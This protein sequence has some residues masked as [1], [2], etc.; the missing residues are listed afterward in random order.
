MKYYYEK[1]VQMYHEEHNFDI[2]HESGTE[3]FLPRLYLLYNYFNGDE[4][5]IDAIESLILRNEYFEGYVASEYD[6]DTFEF[7]KTININGS[8]DNET[9]SLLNES[10]DRIK[11]I[12]N[13]FNIS[14]DFVSRM[15]E[16]KFKDDSNIK[17]IYLTDSDLNSE[18]TAKLKDLVTNFKSDVS[19]VSFNIY[20]KEDITELID[21]VEN[22]KLTVERSVIKLMD[23][24]QYLYHGA[25]KSL[26]VSISAKSLKEIYLKYA[27]KGLFSSN[28]RYYV[29]SARIDKDIKYSIEKE[30]DSFWYFNN[31]IIITA[32]NYK[33]DNDQLT[34]HD[35][36]IVNGGQTTNLIGNSSIS[37]DFS[38][39][40]KVIIPRTTD[41]ETNE[42]FL[43]KV[44]E[45]S[46]TQKPIRARDL[47]ANRP[48]QRKF[49][50]QYKKIDVFLHVKRGEKI[51][52]TVYKERWQNAA[53][54]EVGQMIF[55]FVYQ[56][57]GA[58]K[59]SKSAMLMNKDFYKLIYEGNYSDNLLLSFQHFKVAFN[60]W[61]AAE[62]KS[63]LDQNKIAIASN[64]IFMFYGIAG[65]LAK[66]YI[67]SDARDYFFSLPTFADY[68]TKLE[69]SRW[70]MLNDVAYTDVF[71]DPTLFSSTVNAYKFFDFIYDNFVK[72]AYI[73]FKSDYHNFGPGHF[74]KSD[75]HYTK[76]VIRQILLI[77]KSKF[78][79]DEFENF[80]ESYYISQ[81]DVDLHVSE[82]KDEDSKVGLED[83]LKEYR[84]ATY[85]GT[86]I[87]AYEVFT[88]KQLEYIVFNKPKNLEEL[89]KIPKFSYTQIS[90]YGDD[91]I[92][93]VKRY[94]IN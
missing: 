21:D 81:Y 47:I 58:A 59:N 42:L 46:N 29:K 3:V 92:D 10:N 44:A 25:E 1:L 23:G 89:K 8:D 72:Q 63:Q 93:I 34:L 40:C 22:P 50:T 77:L 31:G 55:S 74:T 75:K 54:D 70:M 56:R 62:K 91:I 37:E 5:Y 69:F 15:K 6:E 24:G 19:N 38:I 85:V 35:F 87:K 73:K 80:F 68:S 64:S 30:P 20:F 2:N 94:I 76:Y 90:N 14:K 17:I 52:K 16:D 66:L 79:D 60:K 83:A 32:S 71:I 78:Y 88:N 12:L 49:K 26:I 28:L 51:D 11:D 13:K 82:P 86:R 45:T 33:L 53:N 9:L 41:I 65:F 27:T 43:A 7:I 18:E 39:L 36:S 48:E 84:T 4:T 57:P 61:K 67:N